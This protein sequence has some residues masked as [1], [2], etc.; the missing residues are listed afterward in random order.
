MENIKESIKLKRAW[1]ITWE[2]MSDSA[3]VVDSIAGII[4]Y[5][6][7]TKRIVDLVE[8]LYNLNTSNLS[9]LAAYANN[10]KNIPYKAEVDF[11]GRITCGSHPFLYARQVQNIEVFVDSY[12]N[13]ETISWETFPT[14]EPTDSVPQKVSDTRKE[15]LK[16]IIIG[17]L[18][19]DSMWDRKK[20]KIK[21]QYLKR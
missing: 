2:W 11:N 18:S 5:R 12:S 21:E 16:R 14:Y 17:P 7:S 10:R 19:F 15:G 9:E 8:F 6:R 13:I 4:D 3:S 20:G 1:I